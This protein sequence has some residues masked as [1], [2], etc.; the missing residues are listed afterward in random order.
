MNMT[1]MK[2]ERRGAHSM[3]S[4]PFRK[5]GVVPLAACSYKKGAVVDINGM[6]AV[7]TE[8]PSVTMAKR[9]VSMSLIVLR[10]SL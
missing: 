3:F 5:Y 2:G 6:G 10:A 7:Q 9:E 8:K 4:W 1:D